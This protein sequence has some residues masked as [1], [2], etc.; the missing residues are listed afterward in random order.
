MSCFC[1]KIVLN[2]KDRVILLCKAV[3]TSLHKTVLCRR[4]E[5][6]QQIS[7]LTYQ[8]HLPTIKVSS[9]LSKILFRECFIKILTY[10]LIQERDM[11]KFVNSRGKN[12]GMN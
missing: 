3:L 2:I 6:H 5:D 1:S 4:D 7:T 12:S 11:S 10:Y 9:R 8:F